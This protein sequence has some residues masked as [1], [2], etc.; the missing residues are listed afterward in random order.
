[1]RQQRKI[2]YEQPFSR[3]RCISVTSN[4]VSFSSDLVRYCAGKSIPISFYDFTG[5]AY[6]TVKSPIFQSGDLTLRQVRMYTNGKGLVLSRKIIIAKCRSQMNLLKYYDRH[7]S[8][9]D[10]VFHDRVKVV[11]ERMGRD[12]ASQQEIQIKKPYV[13]TRNEIFLAEARVS[14][15]YW[16]MIK[17]LLPAE[18]GFRK[19]IKSGAQD[20]VNVMLNYG[21]GILYHRVWEAVNA[22]FLNPEV[23][24]LHAWQ[25][26]RPTLVYDLVE[27]Y[28]QAFV[29]RPLF[30]LL[31]KGTS[32]QSIKLKTGTNLLDQATRELVLKTV[33]GRFS[34]LINFRNQ[35]VKAEDII[36][37]QI[38]DFAAV[39]AERKKNYRPFIMSY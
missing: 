17:L 13:K 2:I 6:A 19:R 37:M 21:Y 9:T 1:M 30:S 39:I 16:E 32:Y 33:L 28:R 20:V 10:P 31:T 27:E 5:R 18:V 12:L 24:F 4:G 11:L 23:G 25:Q 35:K 26:G 36:A 38:T 29:D 7:R 15:S 14:S 3:L 34:S 22:A 8:K